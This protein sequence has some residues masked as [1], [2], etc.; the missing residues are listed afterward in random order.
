MPEN[1]S[2]QADRQTLGRNKNNLFDQ[3]HPRS[4]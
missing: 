4:A 3:I 2:S 1:N